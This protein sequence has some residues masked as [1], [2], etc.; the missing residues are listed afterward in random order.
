M[1]F[2]IKFNSNLLPSFLRRII[3]NSYSPNVLFNVHEISI[4][5]FNKAISSFKFENTFKTTEKGR[6]MLT[7]NF[8]LTI[9]SNEEVV[10][11][12]GASTGVTSFEFIE[13]MKDNFL[14]YY[15]TD[16][17][18]N[19]YYNSLNNQYFFFDR[20]NQ[21]ILIVT[22][23]FVVYYKEL[24]YFKFL[25]KKQVNI[26]AN[27]DMNCFNLVS[28]EVIDIVRFNPKI[29]LCEY[30]VFKPWEHRRPTLIKVAN[31]FNLVYF[32]EHE[33]LVAFHNMFSILEDSGILAI[34]DNREF[35]K[36]SVFKKN[37][38]NAF[39]VKSI[40]GGSEIQELIIKNYK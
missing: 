7:N 39:L 23:K 30:D 3:P 37:G 28:K 26:Q 36:S 29:V 25:F 1:R 33:I 14:S 17:N 11:D 13:A 19:V 21:C 8:L 16:L 20:M 31:L 6:H 4:V 35:E 27:K 34:I 22:N 2:P 40:Q 24:K 15:I 18:L 12:V 10:L 9:I 5:D 32:T 38:S